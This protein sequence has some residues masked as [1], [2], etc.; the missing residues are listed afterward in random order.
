MKAR[1]LAEK[2]AEAQFRRIQD[3]PD[4][5][6]EDPF[7][8]GFRRLLEAIQHQRRNELTD[9][10]ESARPEV[11]LDFAAEAGFMVG[12]ALGKRLGGAR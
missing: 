7:P 8:L 6:A 2:L 1:R 11:L 10:Q 3:L 4:L 9:V 12:L 5:L